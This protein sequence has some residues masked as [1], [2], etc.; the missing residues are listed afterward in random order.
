MTDM[1][2]L[3]EIAKLRKELDQHTNHAKALAIFL[4]SQHRPGEAFVP[5][6]TLG[7]LLAQIDS[8]TQGME[9]KQE[10]G[11]ACGT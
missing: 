2:G 7:G 5:N 6:D 10:R 3:R 11:A 8:I 1:D 9:R 4:M